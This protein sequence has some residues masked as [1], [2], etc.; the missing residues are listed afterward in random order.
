MAG[1]TDA[2]FRTLAARMGA[3]LV[4]SEMIA[5]AELLDSKPDARAKAA[6]G[7]GDGHTSVQLA[8]RDPDIT[9][10]AARLLEGEGA[11][12]IDLNL[13]CPAKKVTNGWSGSALM[14][15]P[16]HALR[17]IEA[18]A[19]A[20]DVPVTVKMRLG[21]DADTL[22]APEIAVRA[23][24]AGVAMFTVHG[25][26]RCQFYTGSA[27]WDAIGDV[28]RAVGVPVIANGDVTGP[29]EAR[30]ALRRSGAAGVMVGRGARGRPWVLGEIAAASRGDRS[31]EP[32]GGADLAEIITEHYESMLV[33]YGRDLGPRV[34]RKHLGWYL[35]RIAGAEAL[36]ARVIRMG[37]PAEVVRS[38]R[39]EL[40]GLG[41]TSRR[42]A[43]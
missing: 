39:G 42:I 25:R 24:S 12:I 9:A 22:N 26:T 20:V 17:L 6:L 16:D 10:E 4:V 14:R 37:D 7:L 41:V 8:G 29:A 13:G 34:A 36:R 27:D 31:P 18:V 19:K 32:P 21:W 1:I 28:V 23:E 38:L 35:D 15:E 43:A 3:G 30:E 40:P 11:R 5:S 2:P 33:F